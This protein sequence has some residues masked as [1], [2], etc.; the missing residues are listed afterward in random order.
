M[1]FAIATAATPVPVRDTGEPLTATLAVIV[2]V[3][4]A[5][6]RLLGEDLTLIV[7]VV[8]ASRRSAVPAGAPAGRENRAV[9]EPRSSQGTVPVL[10]SV[11][12]CEHSSNP[13]P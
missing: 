2:A 1:T 11:G 13:S 6:P 5:A 3:P 9:T 8:A 4:F 12:V 7:Q 10:C